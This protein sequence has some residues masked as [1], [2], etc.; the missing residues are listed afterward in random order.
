MKIFVCIWLAFSFTG[1]ESFAHGSPN[2]DTLCTKSSGDAL[3]DDLIEWLQINGACI[4]EKVSI[5]CVIIDDTSSSC[6]I[7][8]ALEMGVG[9]TICNISW[10]LIVKP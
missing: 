9:E 4:N 5:T 1:N 2:L 3:I 7:L 10:K 6:G 8:A